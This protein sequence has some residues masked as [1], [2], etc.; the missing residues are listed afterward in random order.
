MKTTV[1]K[2]FLIVFSCA[3]LILESNAI[4]SN[5]KD[6]E[7]FSIYSN[8][9]DKDCIIYSN[10][11]DKIKVFDRE[12]GIHRIKKV[13]DSLYQIIYSC[14]NPCSNNVFINNKGSEDWTDKLIAQGGSCLIE[15]NIENRKFVA[16][17]VFSNKYKV[18]LMLGDSAYDSA[19]PIWFY[20]ENSYFD[21]EIL[22]INV[23]Q[24]SGSNKK[25][26][27]IKPCDLS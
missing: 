8:C 3:F 22:V 13:N 25:F 11:L 2:Q 15:Y 19:I 6:A 18:I 21:N 14:G 26:K 1:A 24:K 17:E 9:S 4:N 23:K 10:Y 5:S 7:A 27:F 16:R 20:S 12:P